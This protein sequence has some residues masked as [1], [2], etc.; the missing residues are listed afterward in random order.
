MLARKASYQ[1]GISAMSWLARGANENDERRQKNRLL[2][3]GL[4]SSPFALLSYLSLVFLTSLHIHNFWFSVSDWKLQSIFLPSLLVFL[5]LARVLSFILVFF[6][7]SS[8]S[9]A[10]PLLKLGQHCYTSL[11]PSTLVAQDEAHIQSKLRRLFPIFF[12]SCKY[13]LS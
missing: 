2:S 6:F 4:L 12:M 7:P 1:I 3:P 13:L 10:S 9:G 11:S 5:R 8:S